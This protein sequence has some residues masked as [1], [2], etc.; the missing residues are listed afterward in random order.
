MSIFFMQ[1]LPL[2]GPCSTFFGS[3]DSVMSFWTLLGSDVI[4][5]LFIWRQTKLYNVKTTKQNN[6][7]NKQETTTN[8]STCLHIYSFMCIIPYIYSIYH[9]NKSIDNRRKLSR[10]FL[11]LFV[12]YNN[13][14][15]VCVCKNS[16]QVTNLLTT[17]TP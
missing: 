7:T 15:C 11:T 13:Y 9:F 17:D 16:R 5:S 10:F 8:W 2:L 12:P 1:R 4:L 14:V 3:K 6:K